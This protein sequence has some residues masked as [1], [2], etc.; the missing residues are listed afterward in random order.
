MHRIGHRSVKSKAT[1][2]IPSAKDALP[3]LTVR[4]LM[5][6]AVELSLRLQ[7]VRVRAIKPRIF[8]VVLSYIRFLDQIQK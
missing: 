4:S 3:D 6:A 7:K 1:I 5:I 2:R 8:D